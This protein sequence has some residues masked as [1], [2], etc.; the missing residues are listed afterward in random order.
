M[1]SQQSSSLFFLNNH[2]QLHLSSKNWTRYQ[3][4]FK[5]AE[6]LHIWFKQESG[7]YSLKRGTGTP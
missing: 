2:V 1:P 4:I 7:V 3:N 6:P 5:V